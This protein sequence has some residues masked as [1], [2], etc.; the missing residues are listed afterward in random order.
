MINLPV[1]NDLQIIKDNSFYCS[2]I[3]VLYKVRELIQKGKKF[4]GWNAIKYN[5]FDSFPTIIWT[6]GDKATL[7]TEGGVYLKDNP[8]PHLINPIEVPL[9]GMS[10]EKIWVYE[11]DFL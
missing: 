6:T 10:W 5:N 4:L 2:D 7:F 11:I 8:I 3:M 9:V 1:Y